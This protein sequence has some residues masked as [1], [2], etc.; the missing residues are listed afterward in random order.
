MPATLQLLLASAG[1]TSLSC[2]R[3]DTAFLLRK[4]RGTV[5]RTEARA[6]SAG[7]AVLRVAMVNAVGYGHRLRGK[8]GRSGTHTM[9]ILFKAF[10]CYAQSARCSFQKV[11]QNVAELVPQLPIVLS[12]ASPYT[13]LLLQRQ[14]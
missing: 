1:C 9:P 14:Q 7:V 10:S 4:G 11:L 2:A 12:M 8:V 13:L 5:A 6:L 3:T